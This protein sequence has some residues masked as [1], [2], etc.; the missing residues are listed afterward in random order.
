MR[1][2]DKFKIAVPE[3][4][5]RPDITVVSDA[6]NGVGDAYS[7]TIEMVK[8]TRSGAKITV[9]SSRKIERSSFYDGLTIQFVSSFN[10]KIGEI[11]QV[12]VDTLPVQQVAFLN[13][14]V[15]GEFCLLQYSGS[16]F[17]CTVVSGKLPDDVMRTGGIDVTGKD[18]EDKKADRDEVYLANA[19]IGAIMAYA[20]NIVPIGW[21]LCDGRTITREDYAEL[22]DLI[23]DKLPDLR[24]QFVRGLDNGRGIDPNRELGSEQGDAIRNIAGRSYHGTALTTIME[25]N[26]VSGPFF[27]SDF[28]KYADLSSL[29]E[30]TATT[31]YP[32]KVDFDASRVVPTA[33]ENRPKNVA[34]NYIVKASYLSTTV[35]PVTPAHELNAKIETNYRK[36]NEAIL[37]NTGKSIGFNGVTYI[38]DDGE[39][40]VG[41]L[42][43]DKNSDG[44]FKCI[45]SGIINYNSSEYFESDSNYALSDKLKNLLRYIKTT[46]LSYKA[47]TPTGIFLFERVGRI[48]TLTIDSST[49]F[50]TRTGEISELQIP[51]DFRPGATVFLTL[52]GTNGTSGMVVFLHA[53]GKFDVYA[54]YSESKPQ[55]GSISWVAS[56]E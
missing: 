22:Y 46:K 15:D 14:V 25:R 35:I 45:K 10:A 8:A 29:L 39:K 7:G 5:D 41:Y 48:V 44:L 3:L 56:Q 38:Q 26:A 27:G 23:G 52:V 28:K 13:D 16:A 36:Q 43:Y 42:Y 47:S 50:G 34:L 11:T 2:I 37:N 19:P 12:Q 18:L 55:Y 40:V 54:N 30:Y 9:S 49:F 32:Y 33:E 24:G 17:T 20:S 4:G 1:N 31:E 21:L 6:I 51:L 53:S